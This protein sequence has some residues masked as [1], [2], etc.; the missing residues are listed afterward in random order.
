[1]VQLQISAEGVILYA[2]GDTEAL[3]GFRPE[4]LQGLPCELLHPQLLELGLH[5]HWVRRRDG[6]GT[7]IHAFVEAEPSGGYTVRMAHVFGSESER[8]KLAF[9]YALFRGLAFA[10]EY[11]DPEVLDH[12]SRVERYTV[13]IARDALKWPE[14]DIA[15]VTLAAYVHDVGKSA[16]PREILY[17]PAKLTDE[18]YRLVQTHTTKGWVVLE[19]VERH[20]RQQTPWLYDAKSWQWAKQVA[21]HHHENWD[22]SGYPTG[23]SGQDIPMPARVVKVVDVLDAL[24]QARPYKEGW[25]PDRV[26]DEFARKKGI[27]FDPGLVDWLMSQDWPQP[28][29]EASAWRGEPGWLHF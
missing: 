14:P 5:T 18:E 11:G 23:V 17:K 15:R 29:G 27:E 7:L 10:A 6:E 21:L 3:L 2:T 25:P 9:Q 8:M 20:V 16:I 22:G 28:N 26:R 24:I 1:M 13:W 12:L 4:E 19:E